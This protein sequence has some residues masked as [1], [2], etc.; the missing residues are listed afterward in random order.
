MHLAGHAPR[1]YKL[2]MAAA[3]KI[4]WPDPPP[5]RERVFAA[6]EEMACDPEVTARLIGLAA[7]IGPRRVKAILAE[8]ETSLRAELL[9]R[10]M[11]RARG[12]L[13][14]TDYAIS[15]IA[16]LCGYR[17]AS[18]F[19]VRF[20][21]QNE[22]IGPREYRVRRG[23]ARRAGGATGAF[24]KPAE[25]ARARRRGTRQPPMRRKGSLPGAADVGLEQMLNEGRR[26][27]LEAGP[28][29]PYTKA[30]EAE[31]MAEFDQHF[32]REHLDGEEA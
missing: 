15:N 19:A 20:A 8:E 2:D 9:A 31:M 27:L 24:R 28:G 17:D 23:G 1:R 32:L 25:R 5:T 22:G 10:R 11:E 14:D 7:G 21:R 6:L 3:K 18:A 29:E 12:L 30:E 16:L 4:V 13:A 26:R